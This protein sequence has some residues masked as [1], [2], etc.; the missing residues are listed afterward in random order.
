M[1]LYGVSLDGTGDYIESQNNLGITSSQNRSVSV[2]FKTSTAQPR[3]LFEWGGA[4][5]YVT[6]HIAF[7]F[8][9]TLR[10]S[11][12]TG[13]RN[14]AHDYDDGEWHHYV[15]VLEGT[16]VSDIDL[17]IDGAL[18]TPTSTDNPNGVVDTTDSHL[19]IGSDI[20]TS[21]LFTGIVD[22]FLVYNRAL[23]S[24]E[25]SNLYND[26]NGIYFIPTSGLVLAYQM[27]EGTGTTTA[28]TG[29]SNTGD[30]NGDPTWVAGIS[31]PDLIGGWSTIRPEVGTLLETLTT[32]QEVSSTPKLKF[33]GYPACY[34]VP[35]EN[36]ADY[37]TQTENER[38]YAFIIRV[39][40]E[41]KKIGMAAAMNR[42]DGIVD[43][44]I[45]VFDKDDQKGASDR[46]VGVSLPAGYTFLSILATPSAWGEIPGEGL[47]MAEI[48][49]KIKVSRDVS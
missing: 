46:T 48:T 28:D 32:I 44:I 37:E 39:F 33:S 12:N 4:G 18:Q 3:Y 5:W 10:L 17:Y 14:Y 13:N 9:D 1:D 16:K 22:Q 27:D 49:V 36:T 23:T 6:F 7:N 30:L 20:N 29:D 15:A 45:D 21:S 26:G 8:G 41:T 47:I 24:D 25:V 34:V 42:L 19:F 40:Y 38:I 35:S 11:V 2:W 43:Q 31:W